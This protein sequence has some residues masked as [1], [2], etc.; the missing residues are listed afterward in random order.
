[1][2]M[3][4]GLFDMDGSLADY[5]GQLR[6]DLCKCLSSEDLK[7]FDELGMWKADDIEPFK[8]IIKLIKNQPCWWKSLP[9]MPA[10]IAIYNLAKYI[11]FKTHILT[12]GPKRFPRAWKEKVE[13]CQRLFGEEIDIHITSDKGLVYGK[14]LYDDYPEYMLK[15]LKRRPRGLGIM[16]VNSMNKDFVHPQVIKWDGNN[17]DE[18]QD[19]LETCYN[20]E[21]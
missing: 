16:P 10:G 9:V 5:E 12:K 7:K 20:R 14:F 4:I 17:Y 3:N 21:T 1:M 15:W 6:R 2:K 19:A 18:V 13:W 11:G 8:T